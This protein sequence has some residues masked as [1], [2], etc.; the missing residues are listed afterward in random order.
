M[1]F[2]E[3][4]TKPWGWEKWVVPGFPNFPYV[5]KQICT[6][7]PSKCSVHVHLKKQE[8]NLVLSGRAIVSMSLVPM[9]VKTF[10]AGKM[11]EKEVQEIIAAMS[12]RE[13]KIG[14]VFHVFPGWVHQVEALED[15][16]T[17]EV[18]TSEVDDVYRLQDASGRGHGRIESEHVK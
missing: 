1:Q 13:V 10:A 15:L 18:S 11:T 14:D 2:V 9:D 8:S 16:L 3:I 6:K 4:V 5:L 17:I 7:A 12:T